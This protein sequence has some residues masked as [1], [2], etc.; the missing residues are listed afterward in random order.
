M[1]TLVT[2]RLRIRR[3]SVE[4]AEA[5][6]HGTV[7]P[8]VL[9]ADGYPADTTLVAAGIVVT[10]AREGRNL[11]PWT[12]YQIE[13]REDGAVIAGIGFFDPPDD[14]GI[15]RIGWSETPD[16]RLDEC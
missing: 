4:H 11:G 14:D 10:A 12:A 6:L 9:W 5:I 2:P 8:G 16:A 15:V 1:R 7:P 3:L 13:R